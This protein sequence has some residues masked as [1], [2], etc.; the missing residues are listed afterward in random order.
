MAPTSES[1]DS[2][3]WAAAYRH[4]TRHV[5]HAADDEFARPVKGGTC[6]ATIAPGTTTR[7]RTGGVAGISE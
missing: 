2:M 3:G 1:A 4:H 5:P 7:D 6:C